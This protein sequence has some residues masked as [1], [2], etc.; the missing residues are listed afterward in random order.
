MLK[1]P[2]Q[3]DYTY[4][5]FRL[6]NILGLLFTPKDWF[7]NQ[8]WRFN[9]LLIMVAT[10]VAIIEFLFYANRVLRQDFEQGLR[11][12]LT[13][14]CVVVMFYLSIGTLVLLHPQPLEFTTGECVLSAEVN[15]GYE[16]YKLRVGSYSKHITEKQFYELL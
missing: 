10:W 9:L 11:K 4:F 3:L 6:L 8:Y 13:I 5:F 14:A 1:S 7:I 15:G 12:G 16:S 2:P